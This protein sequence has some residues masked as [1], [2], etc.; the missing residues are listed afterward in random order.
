MDEAETGEQDGQPRTEAETIVESAE[1]GGR[2]QADVELEPIPPDIPVP[3]ESRSTRPPLRSA[4]LRSA[5][6]GVSVFLR[7]V[8]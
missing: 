2:T 6:S 4:A 8:A 3:R 1:N 5:F 7:C